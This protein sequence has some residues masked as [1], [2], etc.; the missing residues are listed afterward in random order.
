M[1]SGMRSPTHLGLSIQA[2][3]VQLPGYWDWLL[4]AGRWDPA[5]R[6]VELSAY[7]KGKVQTAVGIH[8]FLP[9][10][11]ISSLILLSSIGRCRGGG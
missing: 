7:L 11:L 10:F 4:F 3:E 5:F 6:G 1:P 2:I 8:R 9:A